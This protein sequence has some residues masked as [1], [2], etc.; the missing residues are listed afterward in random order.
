[1]AGVSKAGMYCR[2]PPCAL[3]WGGFGGPPGGGGRNTG[4][5]MLWCSRRLWLGGEGGGPSM[6]QYPGP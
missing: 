1:M 5:P 6:A 4:V 2:P 3:Q